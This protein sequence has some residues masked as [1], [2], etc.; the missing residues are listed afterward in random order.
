MNRV[1]K[2]VIIPLFTACTTILAVASPPSTFGATEVTT[3]GQTYAGSGFLS[4]DLDCTGFPGIAVTIDGGSLDLRGFTLTG[5]DLTAILC[6]R[7]CTITS[8]PPGGLL[9]SPNAVAIDGTG[10]AGVHVVAIQIS[11]GGIATDGPI[12]VEDSTINPPGS[13]I[14]SSR[15]IRILRSTIDGISL[16]S[17]GSSSPLKVVESQ[18]SNCTDTCLFGSA[19]RI[20]DSM[21]TDGDMHGVGADLVVVVDS[22]ITG[23]AGNGVVG[24]HSAKIVRSTVSGNSGRGIS[25]LP[26]GAPPLGRLLIRDSDVSGNGL[27]GVFQID[28]IRVSGSTVTMNGRSG[29]STGTDVGSNCP[30]LRL[31]DSTV[32]GNGTDGAVCGVSETCA[33]LATCL[34]PPVLNNTTC[35]TSYDT[36]SGFPGTSWSVC[37]LD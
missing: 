26:S 17:S 25:R 15:R 10:A 18:V 19:V 33:D 37:S 36:D 2:R 11:D 24:Y 34:Q 7:N 14:S 32:T 1:F 27:E 12:T 31:S 28:N 30:R 22:E 5:G 29:I 4:A 9:V 13:Q 20:R 8:D 21:I 16:I 6:A 3:C 23:H 35:N